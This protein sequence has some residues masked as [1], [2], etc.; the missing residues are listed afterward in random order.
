MPKTT[1]EPWNKDQYVR[2]GGIVL[3]VVG[4]DSWARY[5]LQ[6]DNTGWLYTYDGRVLVARYPTDEE[7]YMTLVLRCMR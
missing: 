7:S 4:G 2:I 3:K 1:A 6:S 5:W